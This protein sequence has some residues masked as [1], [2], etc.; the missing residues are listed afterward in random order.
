MYGNAL[1]WVGG[2]DRRHDSQI[3]GVSPWYL[4]P[5]SILKLSSLENIHE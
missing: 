4:L 2:Q 3:L 5:H 1:P